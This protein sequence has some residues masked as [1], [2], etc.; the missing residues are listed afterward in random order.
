MSVKRDINNL[1]KTIEATYGEQCPVCYTCQQYLC[2]DCME[3]PVA[4]V[5]GTPLKPTDVFE[6]KTCKVCGTDANITI[7]LDSGLDTD[8]TAE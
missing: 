4:F 3:H 6:P 7:I 2:D 5:M 1:L 8:G